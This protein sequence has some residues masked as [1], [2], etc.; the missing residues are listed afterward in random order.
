MM[1]SSRPTLFVAALL[2]LLLSTSFATAQET[3]APKKAT[4]KAKTKSAPTAAATKTSK[5]APATKSNPAAKTGGATT[6]Q[7]SKPTTTAATSKTQEVV[8]TPTSGTVYVANKKIDVRQTPNAKE[9]AIGTVSRSTALEAFEATTAGSEKWLHVKYNDG[10]NNGTGWVRAQYTVTNRDELLPEAYRKLD[11]SPQ[12]KTKEYPENPRVKVRGV[13]VSYSTAGIIANAMKNNKP[14]TLLDM[15]A[16]GSINAFVIDVKEDAGMMTF[17][18]EAAEKYAPEANKLPTIKDV[19]KFTQQLKE[20]KIYA[21]ARI[22]TF[23]DPKYAKAH[24]DRCIVFKANGAFYKQK[25]GLIWCS[26]YDRDLWDYD[27]AVAKEAAA[28]GFNEIQFDYVRFPETNP[29]EQDPLLEFHNKFNENKPEAIQKFLK[30]A[31]SELSP[32]KVYVGADVFG[33]I[34]TSPTDE[35]IGQYWEAVSNVVDYIC[36]MAYPSHYAVN[37]FG[38]DIPDAHPYECVLSTMRGGVSRNKNI[39]TPAIVRPWIQDFTATWVKGH[40]K[41]GEA[42]LRGQIRAAK[43][44]GCE[45]FMIWNAGNKYTESA[46]TK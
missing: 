32:M 14:N 18:T 16:R 35:R 34:P 20:R 7:K 43:E 4:T 39:Q 21:I 27:I 26:A 10:K 33:L 13:Y 25:D 17:K 31:Y 36:P 11:F 24:P 30:Q 8:I 15:A 19:K 46:L 5:A 2:A 22:V 40:I 28:A 44:N 23:K 1:L 3:P 29:V 41:Y 12:N 37:T 38:L 9:K 6:A 45:E 42:E